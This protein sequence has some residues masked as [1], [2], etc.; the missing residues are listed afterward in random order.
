MKTGIKLVTLLFALQ[1]LAEEMPSKY[2]NC[3]YTVRR[4]PSVLDVKHSQDCNTIFA[5]DQATAKKS[6]L[7]VKEPK[8]LDVCDDYFRRL[9][10]LNDLLDDATKDLNR[11]SL[12]GKSSSNEAKQ[13]RSQIM[14]WQIKLNDLSK[15]E[16]SFAGTKVKFEF[17]IDHDP[18]FMRDFSWENM[19]LQQLR[20]VV[21]KPMQILEVA[22]SLEL[23]KNPDNGYQPVKSF[24]VSGI[25]ERSPGKYLLT[26]QKR[27]LVEAQLTYHRSCELNQKTRKNQDIS[28][29]LADLLT[30]NA[31]SAVQ[32]EVATP[33]GTSQESVVYTNDFVF[34]ATPNSS[35]PK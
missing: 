26:D 32:M 22:V 17:A 27:F 14:T 31:L 33:A 20:K 25:E 16:Q 18:N 15:T 11:L 21:L 24:A 5:I 3:D 1:G 13:L 10:R 19:Q 30:A 7:K 2:Q 28:M 8:E 6:I 4:T 23:Y 29:D 34:S 12:E 9:R 35:N